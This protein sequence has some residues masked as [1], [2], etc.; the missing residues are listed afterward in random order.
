MCSS[1]R[2]NEDYGTED[3]WICVIDPCK[4]LFLVHFQVLWTDFGMSIWKIDLFFIFVTLC[5][6]ALWTAGANYQQLTLQHPLYNIEVDGGT[7]DVYIGGE[8]ILVRATKELRL[9][10][11][12]PTGPQKDNT[13]C[14]APGVLPECKLPRILTNN[15][16]KILLIDQGQQKL[17]TCGSVYFGACQLRDLNSL[18]LLEEA[19]DKNVASNSPYPSVAFIAPGS[20][21][22]KDVM[23]VGSTWLKKYSVLLTQAAV[24]SV[25]LQKNKLFAFVEEFFNDPVSL[26]EFKEPH[27]FIAKYIYGFS[28]GMFSYFIQVQQTSLKSGTYHTTIGRIC[29]EDKRFVSYVEMPL[30]CRSNSGG[31]YNIAQSAFLTTPGELLASSFGNN[32]DTLFVAFG[33]SSLGSPNATR[34]SAVCVY[35]MSH[36]NQKL[37]ENIKQC[38]K[39]PQN[40]GMAWAKRGGDDCTQRPVSNNLL[41]IIKY[42]AQNWE[43]YLVAFPVWR[44]CFE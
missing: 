31:D 36:V 2:N 28:S 41:K 20:D 34:H 5:I 40:E 12:V 26:I 17:I 29:H 15:R 39:G 24:A 32:G 14:L 9:E 30:V 16:N 11:K 27:E 6:K 8:N 25:S 10:K 4:F 1:F 43:Q 18:S 35:S 23:Y 19:K 42:S 22:G 37:S 44:W 13:D 7:G 3:V 38:Y 21:G 33:N